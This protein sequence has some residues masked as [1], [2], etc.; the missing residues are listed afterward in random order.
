[1]K[2][3]QDRL[4]SDHKT[5]LMV[6]DLQQ[7]LCDAAPSEPIQTVIARVEELLEL[8]NRSGWPVVNWPVRYATVSPTFT[9]RKTCSAVLKTA[10]FMPG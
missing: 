1:M 7:A 4:R 3:E 9:S 2:A 5:A 10:D 6:V 8:A